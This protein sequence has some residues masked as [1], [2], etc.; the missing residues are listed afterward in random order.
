MHKISNT[1]TSVARKVG[2]FVS[3][4]LLHILILLHSRF[5]P[6]NSYTPPGKWWD[7]YIYLADITKSHVLYSGIIKPIEHIATYTIAAARLWI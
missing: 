4:I 2:K 3:C 7:I 6:P 1:L 5:L